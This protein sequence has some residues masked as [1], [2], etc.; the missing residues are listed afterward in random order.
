[1]S[2]GR[3]HA[4]RPRR[5]GHLQGTQGRH[6]PGSKPRARGGNA[7]H[8]RRLRREGPRRHDDAGVRYARRENCSSSWASLSGTVRNCA[9]G[10]TPWGSW[11]TCEETT[12]GPAPPPDSCNPTATSSTCRPS[13]RPFRRPSRPWAVSPTKPLTIDPE[14]GFVYETEDATPS[15]FYRFRPTHRGDLSS[16]TLEMLAIEGSP[17]YNT[18]AES[19]AGRGARRGVGDHRQP[20]SGSRAAESVRAGRRQGRGRVRPARRRL[21]E[22]RQGLLRVDERRQRRRRARSGSTSRAARR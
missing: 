19:D 16:G 22:P 20:R 4:G 10:P 17:N 14:T 12:V 21:V 1:M 13:A 8:P 18:A 9:G 3:A 5:H 7:V 6:P 15:G 11:L 2:D